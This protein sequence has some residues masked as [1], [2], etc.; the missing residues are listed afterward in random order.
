MNWDLWLSLTSPTGPT[1]P[2]ASPELSILDALRIGYLAHIAFMCLISITVVNKCETLGQKL[3]MLF[4]LG[5]CILG[6]VAEIGHF[7]D[8]VNW[9]FIIKWL[10]ALG[11]SWSYWSFIKYESPSHY[12]LAPL[13]FKNPERP[14][15][16]RI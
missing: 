9:I 6:A 14:D 15:V 10:L 5:W 2:W 11:A 12:S 7:G 3:R 16:P 13:S 8:F 4:L 1:T